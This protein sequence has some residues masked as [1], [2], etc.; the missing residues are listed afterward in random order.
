MV[1]L[2]APRGS[3]LVAVNEELGWFPAWESFT[4]FCDMDPLEQSDEAYGPNHDF[5]HV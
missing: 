3:L 2:Q 1:G 5:K 4:Y